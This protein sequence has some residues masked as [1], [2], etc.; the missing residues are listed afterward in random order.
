MAKEVTYDESVLQRP[1]LRKLFTPQELRELRVKLRER[2]GPPPARVTGRAR[3]AG[4]KGPEVRRP[5]SSIARPYSVATH[6]SAAELCALHRG[7]RRSGAPNMATYIL[8]CIEF[9]EGK[10]RFDG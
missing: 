8:A 2:S 10:V 7:V 6:L 5:G 1:A 3:W 9:A 4:W